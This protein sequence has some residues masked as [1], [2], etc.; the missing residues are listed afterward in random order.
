M[1]RRILTPFLLLAVLASAQQAPVPAQ[2][3]SAGAGDQVI[4]RA[5]SQL[6]V[7]TVSVKGKN[8]VPIEGLTAKDFIVTEDG[9]AQ[10]ISVFEYQ[11]LPDAP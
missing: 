1:T 2:N 8:G 7:E 9:V 11:K 3:T 6:V 5:R 10:N 4:F